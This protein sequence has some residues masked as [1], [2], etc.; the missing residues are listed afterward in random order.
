MIKRLQ[1]VDKNSS[2]QFLCYITQF[3]LI[4]KYSTVSFESSAKKYSNLIKNI[5]I[6]IVNKYHKS[7]FKII[8]KKIISKVKQLII[9][10]ILL[11]INKIHKFEASM[12]NMRNATLK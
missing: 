6:K 9:L 11:R 1:D 5:D 7:L 3:K 2:H 12:V 4:L 8:S 10:K